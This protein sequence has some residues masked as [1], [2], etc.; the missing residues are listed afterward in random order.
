MFLFDCSEGSVTADCTLN[1]NTEVDF[2]DISESDVTD[3]LVDAVSSGSAS[4]SVLTIDASSIAVEGKD[5]TNTTAFCQLYSKSWPTEYCQTHNKSGPT[6][7]ATRT[8]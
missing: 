1:F 2:V 6:N 4:L 7:S 8:M 5:A 3:T